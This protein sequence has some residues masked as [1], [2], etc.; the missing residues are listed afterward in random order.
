MLLCAFLTH[1]HVI[2]LDSHW[3]YK[4]PKTFS[5]T[6]IWKRLGEAVARK[7]RKTIAAEILKDPLLKSYVVELI[8]KEVAKELKNM[9][10]TK[11][12]SVL[13]SQDVTQLKLFSWDVLLNEL[14]DV[15]AT[16]KKILICATK[17]RATRS[18]TNGVIGICSAILLNYRNPR[19]N[20]I[21]KIISLILHAGHS[22]KQVLFRTLLCIVMQAVTLQMYVYVCTVT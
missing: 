15:A 20:L 18:N 1:G 5:L 22:S 19:M 8:G 11:A 6:P 13:Q 21:Q 7:K 3:L 10:S 4:T 17:A 12:S 14:S 16:L 9:S 2:F